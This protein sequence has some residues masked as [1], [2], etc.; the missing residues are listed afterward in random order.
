MIY[1]T[2]FF[3]VTFTKIC[4]LAYVSIFPINFFGGGNDSEYYDAYALGMDSEIP[5]IWPVLLRGLNDIGMYSREGVSYFLAFLGILVI[6]LLVAHLSVVRG[7]VSQVRTFWFVALGIAVYP[8]L[9]FYTFDIY[10]DVL[11]VFIFLLGL[12]AI[13]GFIFGSSLIR[14]VCSLFLIFGFGYFLYFLRPY[15]GFGFLIAFLGFGIFRFRTASLGRYL[16]FFLLLVNFAFMLGFLDPILT[17]REIFDDMEGGTNIGIRF[18]PPAMFL[19]DFGKSFFYQIFGFYFPNYFSVIV[20]FLESVPFIVALVY[21]VKN[22]RY[23]N[24]FVSFLVA[25]FIIYSTIW[26]LG[27]DNLGTAVRLRMYSYISV[28]IAAVIIFQRKS[29]STSSNLVLG[30]R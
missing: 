16:I 28:F 20:F 19:P 24:S 13:S 10:R 12:L 2:L 25:F 14:K 1:R 22:R 23:A 17:Y 3:S 18:G 4:I 6:P 7:A 21:L 29:V 26:L 15:L 8:T 5:N 27:N 30:D 11:M 9:F